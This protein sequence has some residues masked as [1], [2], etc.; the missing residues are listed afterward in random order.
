M[1][2]D[3]THLLALDQGTS[4]SRAVVFDSRGAIVALAQ[5]EL[6]L[7]DLARIVLDP[8]GLRKDLP[9]LGLRGGDDRARRIEDDG[10]RA[11]PLPAG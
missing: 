7:P 8:A 9:E 3:T 10:A 11:R 4:S 5:R 2:N 1:P 6:R